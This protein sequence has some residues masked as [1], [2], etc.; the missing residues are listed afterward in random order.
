M[1]YEIKKIAKIV[2]EVIT[3]FMFNYGAESLIE[4]KCR[5]KV[6]H[7]KFR[8]SPVDIGEKEFKKI[9]KHFAVSRHPELENYY[10]QL[11]GEVED[12]NEITLVGMMCDTCTMHLNN[13]ILDMELTRKLQ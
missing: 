12:N 7:M 6:T 13:N 9:E 4:I 2:D 11:A 1:K 3:Y 8:F 10:W 5:N